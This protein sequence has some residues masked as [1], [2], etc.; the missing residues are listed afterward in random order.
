MERNIVTGS[1]I[2]A[3]SRPLAANACFLSH[4]RVA[5][6]VTVFGRRSGFTLLEVIIV[7]T[8]IAIIVSLA[9]PAYQT[10]ILRAKE[11]VLKQNL[12][13]LRRQIEAFAADRG[14]YPQSLQELVEKGYLREIPLDPITGSRDTWETIQEDQ[15]FSGDPEQ[16]PGIKDVKSGAKTTSSEGTPYNEW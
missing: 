10:I 5:G 12:H 2:H 1:A 14:R 13:L 7:L 4:R 9:I 11:S 6:H 8:I 3:E 16:Q 15:P